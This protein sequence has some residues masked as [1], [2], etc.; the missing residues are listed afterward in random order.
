MCV[1]WY[2]NLIMAAINFSIFLSIFQQ[3]NNLQVGNIIFQQVF[4]LTLRPYISMPAYISSTFSHFPLFFYYFIFIFLLKKNVMHPLVLLPWN[5]V[6]SLGC[7]G[8]V[9]PGMREKSVW[10]TATYNIEANCIRFYGKCKI[11]EC[12]W[13]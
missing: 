7:Y 9:W 8:L 1:L 10:K 3:Q 11:D 13:I 2:Y 6:Y 5:N 4:S 12:F